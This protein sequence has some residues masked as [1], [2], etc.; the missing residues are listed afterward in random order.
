[1]YQKPTGM[2]YQQF[3]SELHSSHLFDW[4]LEIGCR[5]GET[6]APCRSKTI[7]VDPFFRAEQNIIAA[8]PELHVFQQTSDDFFAGGFL[9][10]NCIRLSFSFIDGMHLVEYALRDLINV[11]ANSAPSGVIALHDCCPFSR[12]MTTRDLNNLPGG[13]WTGDVW[14]LLPILRRYRPDLTVTVMN[15]RPSGLV[16]LTGLDPSSRVLAE[17]QSDILKEFQEL[18]IEDYGV[19]RFNESFSYTEAGGEAR[20][21]FPLFAGCRIDE[22]AALTPAFVTP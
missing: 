4:Y 2:R 16:L 15:C 11:E 20:N 3:L 8:K 17:N 1:M 12:K 6:F 22:G 14:K 19:E 10:R 18:D 9:A 5:T 13:P 21:G 7:A